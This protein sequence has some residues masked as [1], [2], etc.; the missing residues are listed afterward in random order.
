MRPEEKV[1]NAYFESKKSSL[2]FNELKELSNLSD[3]SLSNTLNKLTE[4]HILFKEKTKSNTFYQIQDKKLM[5]LKFSEIAI[6]RFRNLNR[7]VRVPL[8]NFLAELPE[9]IYT[10]ILFGSAS[11]KEERKESDIDILV[12]ADEALDLDSDRKNAQVVSNHTLSIFR[13]N[14][15]EFLKNKDHVILQ[16]R[17]TGFAI[18]KEQNFYE[19]VLDGY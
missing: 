16:A 19:V 1:Y 11:R 12:V 7:G 13:C 17:K 5:A 2:Y 15:E 10:V 14:I 8:S 4:S 6:T 9:S 18:H 3:S